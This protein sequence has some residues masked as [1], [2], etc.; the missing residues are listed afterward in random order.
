MNLSKD[1]FPFCLA[2]STYSLRVG[3]SGLT[4]LQ[5]VSF[6]NSLFLF[7]FKKNVGS[8]PQDH[9]EIH[10]SALPGVCGSPTTVGPLRNGT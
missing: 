6:V 5:V 1:N 7:F 8:H 3:D 9:L 4:P 10:D 2:G